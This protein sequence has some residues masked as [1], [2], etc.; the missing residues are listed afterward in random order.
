MII[1]YYAVE[2]AQ[3]IRDLAKEKKI[4]IKDMLLEIKLNKNS[5]NTLSNGSMIQCDSLAKIADYLDCSVDYLL[6]RAS[7]VNYSADSFT[8]NPNERTMLNTF[9]QLSVSQQQSALDYLRYL[10]TQSVDD[11][12]IIKTIEQSTSTDIVST[13]AR[14]GTSEALPHLHNNDENL[15]S[16]ISKPFSQE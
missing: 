12:I 1:L 6:G 4:T 8:L 5:I 13:A 14:N 7:Q 9:R 3:K 2:I 10:L 16:A 15:E 11:S